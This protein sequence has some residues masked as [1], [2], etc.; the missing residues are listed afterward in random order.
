MPEPKERSRAQQLMGDFA[1]KLAELTDD[2]LF[3]DVNPSAKLPVTF[4]HNVG[5]V[6]I[7]YAH[8]NT[9]RPTG[10]DGRVFW[11]HYTDTPNT[12][13]YPFGFGLSYTTFALSAPRLSTT[14]IGPR[15]TLRRSS[16]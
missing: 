12:P 10:S 16:R 1:P 7:Y 14:A 4:P 13:L 9:G 2:V 5:Q 8:K 6:P 11:S 15:D 3:G